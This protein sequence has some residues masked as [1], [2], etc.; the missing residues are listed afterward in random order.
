MIR[1]FRNLPLARKVLLI[2]GLTLLL[3]GSILGL[4]VNDAATH[5]TSL[6]HQK[7]NAF[8]PL[9][10]GLVLKDHMSSVH[11]QLFA[12][13]SKR[14]TEDDPVGW[15]RQAAPSSSRRER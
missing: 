7:D 11:G 12:L 3:L 2:P 4:A 14:A 6:K 9:Y 5:I 15:K 1:Y 10:R 8:A 13:L